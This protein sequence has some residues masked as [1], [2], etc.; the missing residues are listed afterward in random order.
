MK[1]RAI[2]VY[3]AAAAQALGEQAVGPI[4]IVATY[5]SQGSGI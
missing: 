4:T 3:R 2:E 5:S 1:P